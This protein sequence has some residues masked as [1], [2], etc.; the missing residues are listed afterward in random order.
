MPLIFPENRTEYL[1]EI[2]FSSLND[3]ITN[4]Q[5]VA[6]VS[7]KASSVADELGSSAND[8][9][10]FFGVDD[11]VLPN[12][13]FGG[14]TVNEKCV[15]FLPQALSF[16]DKA[17][18]N[19]QDLGLIGGAVEAGL[20]AAD[21]GT[22]SI[23]SFIDGLRG[24]NGKTVGKLAVQNVVGALGGE[25]ITGALK[26][27]NKITSNPN[28]RALFESVP[29][30]NFD[31]T[32]KMIPNS[33][34]EARNIKEI[35]AFFRKELYPEEIPFDETGNIPLSVGYKFP[36]KF[37]IQ[38]YYGKGNRKK[39]VGIKIKP[40]YLTDVTTVFNASSMGMHYDGEFTEVDL[41][42]SFLEARALSRKDILE[43]GFEDGI[44]DEVGG[45]LGL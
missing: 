11:N 35:I 23:N 14:S 8:V 10:S 36:N 3:S 31:F 12:T 5:D 37:K 24:P 2:H 17:V 27:Q 7:Q 22:G 40:C 21:A 32:F 44:L 15:L 9:L 6:A 13:S 43:E 19:A 25:Q 1:G 20:V 38:M 34:Q 4:G 26:S 29:L 33:K 42:I 18:Y 39:E 30:R 45:S 16:S 28:T 41:T